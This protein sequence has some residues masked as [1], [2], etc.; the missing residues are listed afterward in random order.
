LSQDEVAGD[1]RPSYLVETDE[2]GGLCEHASAELETLKMCSDL[3]SVKA[4][5]KAIKEGRVHVGKEFSVAAIGRH[6]PT[7]YGAK[8]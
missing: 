7:D 6:A 3:T 5:V 2:I 8:P 1:G 4:A